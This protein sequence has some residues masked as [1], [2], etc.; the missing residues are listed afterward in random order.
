MPLFRKSARAGPPTPAS[1]P[2]GP[3]Q[4][5]AQIPESKSHPLVALELGHG[6][7]GASRLVPTGYTALSRQG[8]R[9]NPVVYRSTRLIAEAASSVP[10]DT[11]GL[12]APSSEDLL[13]MATPDCPAGSLR[14]SFFG[15]LQIGGSAYLEATLVDERPVA[16]ELVRPDRVE[17]A[18]D[19]RGRRIGWHVE[20]DRGRRLIRRDPLTDR[21]PLFAFHLFDPLDPAGGHGPLEA[22]ARS[23][24]IH[25][26]G[27]NWTQALLDNSARPSGALVYRGPTGGERLS[28]AQ[29]E[30]LKA[31]LDAQHTGAGAAG[32]PLL[33]EGGL[34]WKSMSLS[35]S[36]MDF[37]E[38]RREAARE[39][40]FAFGVPPM[41][42][43]IPGDNTYS[44]Y[45][46]ANLA[47]WRQTVLPLVVR[48]ACA[49]EAWLRAWH[50]ERV[51]VT[52]KLDAVPALA[53][54][55]D[56]L[57]ARVGGAQFLS[58]A[59]RRSLLGLEPGDV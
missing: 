9:R 44:N 21:S 41:L 20:T 17:P 43:G 59:E 7:A 45:R 25:N 6:A 10:L 50:G 33:L 15:Q 26:G 32:R 38:A 1:A 27:A 55:R 49:W 34:D 36:D 28:D 52:P 16:L 14:E 51:S 47:F 2:P 40:A 12:D 39:I 24:S 46:E 31:E 4:Q 35:P 30:R 57:W 56:G 5:E 23:V 11:T 42:L 54:E 37:I 8:F 13:G 18:T 19:R 53:A 3:Y 48:F 22:C 58:D 29:F